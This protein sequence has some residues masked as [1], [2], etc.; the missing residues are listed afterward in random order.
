MNIPT[1][2]NE[3]KRIG[4]FDVRFTN[5]GNILSINE[6]EILSIEY[7]GGDWENI[8]YKLNIE[9]IKALG[10]KF[11]EYSK[12]NSKL[13]EPLG[14]TK[15]GESYSNWR[16]SYRTHPTDYIIYIPKQIN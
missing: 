11:A 14:Q 13:G 12:Y 8:R 9:A 1:G 15:D 10:L 16:T 5:Y 3:T 7:Y 6:I 4:G 2:E